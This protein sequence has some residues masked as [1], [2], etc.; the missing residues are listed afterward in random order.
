MNIPFNSPYC[1]GTELDYI[2]QAF[3]NKQ[4]SGDGLFTKAASGIL[5]E[6]FNS[7]RA[8][9]THSCTAALEMC[10]ILLELNE[11]DEVIMPSFTFVSTANA[12][13]SRGALPVFVDI[14]PLTQNIDIYRIEQAITSRTKAIVV[15]HYA[16]VSCNLEHLLSLAQAYQLP[17]VEDAA[18]AIYSKYNNKPLGSFG[19]LA[20]VSFHET[21]NISCG[22][23]GCLL[24]NNPKYIERAEIIREKGTNRSLYFRG[25]VDKYTW[26]DVGSSYLPG[27]ISAAFLCAQL[28]QGMQI[29]QSRLINWSTYDMA[30]REMI[31]IEEIQLMHIPEPSVHNAHMYYFLFPDICKR[32]N[33]I[34]YMKDQS[35]GCVFHY[36]PLHSSPAGVKYGK[37]SGS[38]NN[39]DRAGNCLVRLPMGPDLDVQK[40]V[41]AVQNYSNWL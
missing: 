5:E 10:A 34:Q 15:V 4:L 26:V 27:E 13:I 37:I 28:D 22:E 19:D 24:I 39:T 40:V 36:V 35:I 32:T 2:R 25:E 21:K 16:G 7:K 9:L 20:T 41:D 30:F 31:G 33:F 17:I 6:I 3:D 11:G 8:L 12:F 18:Q 23:G 14:D 38:M 29:T 1:C